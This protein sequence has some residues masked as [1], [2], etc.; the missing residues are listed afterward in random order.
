L[1][2]INQGEVGVVLQFGRYVR[3]LP[4]GRHHY[5]LA[6]EQVVV[7]DMKTVTLDLPQQ[8]MITADNL[9]VK[10]DGVCYFKVF[11]AYKAVFNVDNY[12]MALKN[13]ASVMFRTVVG[14]HTLAEVFAERQKISLRMSHLLDDATNDWGIKVDR[15][16][17]KG[18][19]MD[20]TM[21]RAMAAKTEAAQ[22]AEAKIIQARAQRDSSLILSEAAKKMESEPMAMKLQWFETLRVISF[23]GKNTTI[24]VPD[25]VEAGGP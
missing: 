4:P 24:I 17:M 9:T 2:T 23:Q 18:I 22:E 20:P 1:K 5:N 14:E 11:D 19:E 10:V 8:E 16:E 3:T 15:V 12:F 25:K 13:L 7:V 21:Q 6:S